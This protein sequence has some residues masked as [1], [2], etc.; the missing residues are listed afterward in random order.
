[1]SNLERIIDDLQDAINQLEDVRVNLTKLALD[2]RTPETLSRQ[3]IKAQRIWISIKAYY[4][5]MEKLS[6]KAAADFLSKY[7]AAH[8][9]LE[10]IMEFIKKNSPK[11]LEDDDR[12]AVA[13]ADIVDPVCPARPGT[14]HA[15]EASPGPER[16]ETIK[17]LEH[18]LPSHPRILETTVLVPPADNH[19]EQFVAPSGSQQYL[20]QAPHQSQ[21]ESTVNQKQRAQAEQKTTQLFNGLS[22]QPTY[23]YEQGV[24]FVLQNPT[25]GMA[26]QEHNISPS[27]YQHQPQSVQS[28]QPFQQ[29]QC[30]T[31]EEL[32]HAIARLTLN[33]EAIIAGRRDTC[34]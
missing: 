23:V 16:S 15:N 17:P 9:I 19:S 1:M 2:K 30:R 18:P 14:S 27:Y 33:R 24:G 7:E 13:D 34:E 28:Q 12:E 6:D 5:A 4:T 3:C 22:S 21:W 26:G 29:D 25:G 31:T 32:L 10:K 20:L 8:T 11:Q